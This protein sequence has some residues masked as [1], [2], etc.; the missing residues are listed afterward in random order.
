H[1]SGGH[2]SR[3]GQTRI[4]QDADWL[5]AHLRAL[6]AVVG[7]DLAA[8]ETVAAEIRWGGGDA[9]AVRADCTVE[10]EVSAMAAEV[11]DR[12]GPIEILAAFAGGDGDPIATARETGAHWRAVVETNL[13]ATFL[14]VAALLPGMVE[15]RRGTIIT[16]SSAAARQAAQ[17]GAAY[18]AAKA[19]VVALTRHLAAEVAP[20]GVRVNCLAPSMIVSERVRERTTPEQLDQ[21]ASWFPLRRLGRPD[22]VAAATLFLASDASSWITGVTLDVAGGK[23]MV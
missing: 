18:A 16:M 17:S 11:A 1:E 3:R 7:R 20:D 22:D 5:A 21:I 8:L 13:T 14:T 12:L 4:V 15:H 9:L 23:V 6:V 19:G 10:E 2:R